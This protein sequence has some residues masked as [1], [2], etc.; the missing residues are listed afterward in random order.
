MRRRDFLKTLSLV[1]SGTALGRF[2]SGCAQTPDT[3]EPASPPGKRFTIVD[4]HAHPEQ[5]FSGHPPRRDASASLDSMRAAALTGCAFAAVGDQVA[6]SRGKSSESEYSST[7]KQLEWVTQQADRGRLEI[8]FKPAE[9]GWQSKALLQ[10]ILAIEGGDCLEGG[11]DRLDAFYDRGVRTITLMHYTVNAIG[12]IQT[13]APQHKGITAFGRRCVEK[14][15]AKGLLVDVTHAHALTLKEIVSIS[16]RPLIDSHTV[17]APVDH[18]SESSDRAIRRMRSW[19]EMEM[20]A[21]T[22]GLVC[23]PPLQHRLGGLKRETFA[24]WANEILQMKQRLGIEHIGLGTDGG[25]MM[26]ALINGYR[27]YR[28]LGKLIAA[29]QAVGLSEE[30]TAAYLGRNYLRLLAQSCG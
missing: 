14:M 5:F 26:P 18:P 25:G 30:D 9:A 3:A 21:E 20:V 8:V 13:E 16:S 2:L 6:L 27:D 11:L 19:K 24:D 17:P 29:M 23:T 22:G 15:Q 1:A 7:L 10:A 4:A 28:D 12:D